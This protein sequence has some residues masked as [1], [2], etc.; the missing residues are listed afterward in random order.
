[1]HE[2]ETQTK[3]PSLGV[4]LVGWGGNNGST[5]TAGILANR[6]S[7]SWETKS[8]SQSAN[9]WGSFT[10]CSSTKV[11]VR[12]T[13]D[14]QFSE[15]HKTIKDLVP[16]VNPNDL[17]ITGWD[18][19]NLNLYDSCKRAKVL[20]PTLLEQ[21]KPQLQSMSPMKAAFQPEY[22]ASNQADRANN[23]L[24]GSNQEVIAQLRKD[25]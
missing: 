23:T 11:G 16:L 19:S 25:I 10:Q 2:I 8:G 17:K 1:M 18:I 20:E 5:L 13:D 14:N 21:L 24:T 6:H 22:V 7:L 4:M 12:V 3:I 15:V 9:Y